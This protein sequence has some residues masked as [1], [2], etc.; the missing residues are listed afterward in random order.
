MHSTTVANRTYKRN[1]RRRA[2]TREQLARNTRRLAT[3][4]LLAPLRQERQAEEDEKTEARAAAAFAEFDDGRQAGWAADDSEDEEW[5][6]EWVAIHG[7][8]VQRR[9]WYFRVEWQQGPHGEMWP[10]QWI[11]ENQLGSARVAWEWLL[12]NDWAEKERWSQV[13]LYKVVELGD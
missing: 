2:S 1:S 3:A 4:A 10:L 12:D 8:K 9:K 5:G 7:L 13:V 11:E 6:Y